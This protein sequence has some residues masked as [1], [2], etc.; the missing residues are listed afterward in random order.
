MES[1]LCRELK[2]RLLERELLEET[3]FT[4]SRLLSDE[5]LFHE[6]HFTRDNVTFDKRVTFF[7]A[8]VKGKI[9]LQPEEVKDGGWFSFEEARQRLTFESSRLLLD[10]VAQRV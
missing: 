3:G 6:Y 1:S 9:Q 7:L 8:E 2:P 4:L 10:E 5:P